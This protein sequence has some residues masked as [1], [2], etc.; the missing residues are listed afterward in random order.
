MQI[1]R[2]QVFRRLRNNT[3]IGQGLTD[4]DFKEN[5]GHL[6]CNLRGTEKAVTKAIGIIRNLENDVRSVEVSFSSKV[7]SEL[8]KLNVENSLNETLKLKFPKCV[9]RQEKSK[10]HVYG[11]DVTTLRKAK[12]FIS[13]MVID[14]ISPTSIN[15]RQNELTLFCKKYEKKLLVIQDKERRIRLIGLKEAVANAME[16]LFM[17][18]REGRLTDTHRQQLLPTDIKCFPLDR[19]LQLHCLEKCVDFEAVKKKY[20]VNIIFHQKLMIIEITGLSVNIQKAYE[21]V[22]GILKMMYCE[23]MDQVSQQASTFFGKELGKIF[24][25]DLEQTKQVYIEKEVLY[26]VGRKKVTKKHS[27]EEIVWLD[28]KEREL[29]LQISN[30]NDVKASAFAIPKL[31]ESK[32]LRFSRHGNTI[33]VPVSPWI[34]GNYQ[35][36]EAV[37]TKLLSKA[38]DGHET[39]LA[40]SMA[41]FCNWPFDEYMKCFVK[42]SVSWLLDQSHVWPSCVI[43]F[44]ESMDHFKKMDEYIEQCVTDWQKDLKDKIVDPVIRVLKQQLDQT[45]A[46]VLVNTTGPNLD[47]RVGNVSAALSKAVGPDLQKECK[48]KF[49]NG[50]S[51]GTIA[52]TKGFNLMC[53]QLFHI[54][55]PYY[56][57]VKQCIESIRKAVVQCLET[58][59]TNGHETIAFPI[60]G[61]GNLAYPI[62]L[63][64]S[65][66]FGSVERYRQSRPDKPLAEVRFVV[67]HKDTTLYEKFKKEEDKQSKC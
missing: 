28:D 64:C 27:L 20:E 4:F 6:D 42:I 23:K 41:S 11:F 14:Y 63:V 12:R 19:E 45:E 48:L 1:L 40:I 15:L 47:L 52:I 8:H 38:K 58:A 46:D 17:L 55:L 31:D 44:T 37:A 60:I 24:L 65:E 51:P 56:V 29:I 35:E 13:G 39:T 25:S 49:P 50:I 66:M 30:P 62:E 21:E 57:D 22:K 26:Y 16:E 36:T 3:D 10:V 7:M 32:G 18:N 34:D 2:E 9:V 53:K 43:L 5:S 33:E 59:T 67:Y 54:T 61:S